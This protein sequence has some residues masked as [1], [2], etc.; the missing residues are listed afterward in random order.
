VNAH[1]SLPFFTDRG[2]V[3]QLEAHRVPEAERTA[4]GLPI[5]NLIGMDTKETITAVLGVSDFSASDFLLMATRKGEIK[6]TPLDEFAVVRSNGLIAMDLENGD[7]L[8][9]VKHCKAG[10]EILLITEQGQAI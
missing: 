1:D 7:E 3:F 5:I 2:R 9:W 4:K 6:K 10:S 8:A